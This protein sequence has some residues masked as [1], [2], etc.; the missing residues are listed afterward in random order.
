MLYYSSY[1]PNTLNFNATLWQLFLYIAFKFAN[2]E[3]Y[4]Q[5]NYISCYYN[6]YRSFSWSVRAKH[7]LGLSFRQFWT[8]ILLRLALDVHLDRPTASDCLYLRLLGLLLQ[9]P[10]Y[11]NMLSTQSCFNLMDTVES[12]WTL[13]SLYGKSCIY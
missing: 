8:S 11:W 4:L 13:F 3:L 7:S 12:C 5:Y 1:S 9:F 2:T 6:H 10:A